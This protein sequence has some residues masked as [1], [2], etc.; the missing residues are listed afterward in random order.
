M[1]RW[2][3][4]IAA[5]RA[6]TILEAVI[7]LS[8]LLMVSLSFFASLVV[9]S[10][11]AQVG[12]ANAFAIQIMDRTIEDLRGADFDNIGTT[13]TTA[14]EYRFSNPQTFQLPLGGAAQFLNLSVQCSFLGYGKISAIS[15]SGLTAAFPTNFPAWTTNQWQGHYVMITNGGGVG[16]MAYI[17]S[18]TAN[19]L[20]IS[21][22]LSGSGGG[23]W[24]LNPSVGD[25]FQI[26]NGKTVKVTITWT[27][28]RRNFTMTRT[29]LIPP[30]R[31]S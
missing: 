23:G 21:R 29:A 20:T 28:A 9:S 18:N 25:S 4:R 15:G 22:N 7:S 12:K 14:A 6:F 8:I 10:R 30:P 2:K 13:V 31:V 27:I 1:K 24:Y 11:S 3:N 5:S 26:D 17:N 19:A 16:Q